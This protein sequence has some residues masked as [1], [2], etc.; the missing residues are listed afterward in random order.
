[1]T[2]STVLA[3]C[4]D[5]IS[6]GTTALKSEEGYKTNRDKGTFILD[7]TLRFRDTGVFTDPKGY[8][9][10]NSI[11]A[12]AY[13]RTIFPDFDPSIVIENSRNYN[14][15]ITYMNTNYMQ[16]A[17]RILDLYF[18]DQKDKDV[19][20]PLMKEILYTRD[21]ACLRTKSTDSPQADHVKPRK[22]GGLTLLSNAQRLC[23]ESN[24]EKSARYDAGENTKWDFRSK[25]LQFN[26]YS[27]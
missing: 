21:K 16:V 17:Y 13:I 20:S 9:S 5:D 22:S 15:K 27:L 2:F 14:M 11:R 19:F 25:N 18:W 23:Q 24:G 4:Y 6:G 10:K 8:N 26:F 7:A 3:A 1:M 12:L